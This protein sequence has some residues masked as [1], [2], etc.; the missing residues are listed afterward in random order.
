MKFM[1]NMGSRVGG[2]YADL[3]GKSGA[4]TEAGQKSIRS[5]KT[6]LYRD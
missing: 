6:S 5:V 4:G 3:Y 1:Q 2:D